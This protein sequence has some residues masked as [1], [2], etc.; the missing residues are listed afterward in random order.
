MYLLFIQNNKWEKT[1]G[2]KIYAAIACIQNSQPCFFK[3]FIFVV[4]HESQQLTSVLRVL[5]ASSYI[6]INKRYISQI[7][8]S[9]FKF[10]DL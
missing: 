9:I 10:W 6:Y 8:C 5:N 4:V 1:Y 2:Q 7:N 3:L